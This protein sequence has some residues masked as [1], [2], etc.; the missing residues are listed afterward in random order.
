MTY[1]VIIVFI[2]Y[3][4]FFACNTYGNLVGGADIQFRRKVPESAHAYVFLEAFFIYCWIVNSGINPV[5]Y[6]WKNRDFRI[7]FRKVN[8]S[9]ID[10]TYCEEIN[11]HVYIQLFHK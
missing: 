1:V 3:G 6:Q 10:E 4:F 9:I 11:W 8:A 5:I 2:T 7:A